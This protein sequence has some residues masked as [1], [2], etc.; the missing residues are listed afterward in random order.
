MYD[1]ETPCLQVGNA[2]ER[3]RC[4]ESNGDKKR[5]SISTAGAGSTRLFATGRDGRSLPIRHE[6]RIERTRCVGI[7]RQLTSHVHI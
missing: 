5:Q 2:M 7:L 1:L 4:E 6:G 3:K